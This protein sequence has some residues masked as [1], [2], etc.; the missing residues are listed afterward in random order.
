VLI[1]ICIVFVIGYICIAFEHPLH[2]NKAASALATGVVCWTLYALSS[3]S[4][5]APD[6]IPGSFI[7]SLAE[8]NPDPSHS[9]SLDHAKLSLEYLVEGQLHKLVA[10]TAG[11]LFF[12]LGAMTIV[13]LVDAFEGFK[14]VTDRIRAT[15][16][17]KL[18]WIIGFVTFF[19]S[20]VLDNLTTTIVMISLLRKLVKCRETRLLYVGVVVIA[21]N[22][23][24]AWTVIG[25]V[26]T[27]MLWIKGKISTI[28]V[29]IRLVIPSLVCLIAPLAILS[30]FMKGNVERPEVNEDVMEKEITS[31]QQNLMLTMG[32][33]GLLSVPIYKMYTHLPPFMGMMGALSVVW[34]VS[35]LIRRHI[36]HEYTRSTTHIM[37]ILKRVDSSAILFFLGILLA[38]G[39]LSSTGL[40]S[41]AA[42]QLDQLVGNQTI[43]AVLIGLLSAVVDNVPLVAAGIEMYEF[44]IDHRFWHMLAFCA[45]T[46]GSCLIIGSAAGV[47]AM[48]L[49]RIDFMWYLRKIAPLA[50]VGYLAGAGLTVFIEG[51]F[52]KG[53]A[54][55]RGMSHAASQDAEV[56]IF[57]SQIPRMQK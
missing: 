16:K 9:Q 30:F 51:Y 3:A 19:M 33:L 56:A 55:S 31:T 15:N 21:A 7:Q 38:V 2:I 22:A 37:E 47:A 11:I 24:G 53:K 57:R 5:I 44:P 4:L 39:S 20:S 28:E 1:A 14:L 46:G 49:E 18:L 50:L 54:D 10:E 27:T 36:D 42:N 34:I 41:L 8:A 32:L 52:E 13:E 25:D 23:G 6:Q 35:E 29:M 48:G 45:G 12:L 17:V 40:L 43:V 26:T